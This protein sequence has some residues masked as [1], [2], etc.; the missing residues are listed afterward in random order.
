MASI[1]QCSIALLLY[2]R[3]R[4]CV[5]SLVKYVCL[6]GGI[7]SLGF[8]VDRTSSSLSRLDLSG[9]SWHRSCPCHLW[10]AAIVWAP[11]YTAVYQCL[12]LAIKRRVLQYRVI[13]FTPWKHSR[14]PGYPLARVTTLTNVDDTACLSLCQGIPQY[15]EY[16]GW[17]YVL[18]MPLPADVPL[19]RASARA[20]DLGRGPNL[21]IGSGRA[22]CVPR[23]REHEERPAA[24]RE[25]M[26][27]CEKKTHLYTSLYK[28]F[29]FGLC[30]T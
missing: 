8:S 5:G 10:Q 25:N 9:L 11:A 16:P 7:T 26:P 14:L 1:S 18:G 21:R 15:P 4:I 24:R 28:R 22:P 17:L 2:R 20:T 29:P 23:S 12:C 3:S 27:M 19:S 30:A 13:F 6:S